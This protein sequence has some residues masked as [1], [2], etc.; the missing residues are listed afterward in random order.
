MRAART[1]KGVH[2]AGNILS[3]KMN[4]PNE[5]TLI[6]DINSVLPEQIRVWGK[7]RNFARKHI[8]NAF[9]R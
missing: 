1:D 9:E 2:A 4:I 5:E 3:L 6:S 7:I 8:T